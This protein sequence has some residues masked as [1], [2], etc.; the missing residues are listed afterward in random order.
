MF[1][2]IHAIQK[3]TQ[4]SNERDTI[5]ENEQ[6]SGNILVVD[7]DE[8]ICCLLKDILARQK[9][10]VTTALNGPQ[11]L[12]ILSN[13][14]ID[15][16]ITDVNMPG[17]NGIVLMEE[18]KKIAPDLPIIVITGGGNEEIAIKALK[19]GAFN[20]C[21]KPFE[22]GELTRIVEKGLEIKKFSDKQK[23]VLPFLVVNLSFDIPSDV[24]YIRSVIHH[25]YKSAKQ[26]GFPED[27]FSMRVKLAL[28]E[29]LTN[30]IRHGNKCDPLKHVKV[31]TSIAP[32]QLEVCIRDEGPGFD[33]SS[34][35]DPKD[36]ANLYT[37]G[38]RGV[39]LMNYYMDRV[40]FN[41]TG[42]EVV[43]TKYAVKPT[44]VSA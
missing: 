31:K 1:E 39:L 4:H 36:P 22:I 12:E 28:D 7:D 35:P 26:L 18:I 41:E 43:L 9:C 8:L 15:I 11:A 17:M 10:A 42:N 6:F 29:A 14:Q 33:V 25:I 2:E 16:V 32:D 21:R 27:E 3:Q 20:F 23:K 34:I 30:A 19:S 13:A 44:D 24:E 37:E 5:M 40:T 38:G